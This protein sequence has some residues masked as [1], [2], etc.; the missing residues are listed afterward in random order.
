MTTVAVLERNEITKKA[1]EFIAFRL[2]ARRHSNAFQI[3]NRILFDN[4]LSIEL[5]FK[6]RGVWF[7]SWSE[8][9]HLETLLSLDQ[10]PR[11]IQGRSTH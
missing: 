2:V 9:A 3:M 10:R 4:L 1:E 8:M 11:A 7:S 6:G 5:S